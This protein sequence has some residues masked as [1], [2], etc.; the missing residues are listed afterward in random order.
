MLSTS[1]CAVLIDNS[2]DAK[3]S[4]LVLV[5]PHVWYMAELVNS[6]GP[7]T[8]TCRVVHMQ[9]NPSTYVGKSKFPL[10]FFPVPCC[11]NAFNGVRKL[12]QTVECK[13]LL[14]KKQGGLGEGDSAE[15]RY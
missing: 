2:V 7:P 12:V 1:N 15:T 14:A 13:K 6:T 8:G 4:R 11:G 9:K 5:Q 3:S 10:P